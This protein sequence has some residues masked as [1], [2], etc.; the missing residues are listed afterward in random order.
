[1]F[2]LKVVVLGHGPRDYVLSDMEGEVEQDHDIIA[3]DRAHSAV[4]VRLH[5]FA[6]PQQRARTRVVR[7]PASSS[8]DDERAAAQKSAELMARMQATAL[9]AEQA[10]KEE[11]IRVERL[12]VQSMP[13]G[14][15]VIG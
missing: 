15:Q 11:T 12:D 1:M 4:I 3:W 14:A 9:A 8:A 6:A 2:P 10:M 5:L 13:F 7:T